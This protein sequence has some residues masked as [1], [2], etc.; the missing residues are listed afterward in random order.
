MNTPLGFKHTQSNDRTTKGS[1][2][3]TVGSYL[4][5]SVKKRKTSISLSKQ[6][7]CNECLSFS[8]T[9]SKAFG[10]RVVA[11]VQSVLLRFCEGIASNI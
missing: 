3:Q 2:P 5:S 1:K 6:D 8:G 7:I 10:K 9:Y 11:N 4:A